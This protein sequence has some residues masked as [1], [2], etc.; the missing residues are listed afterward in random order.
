[1]SISSRAYSR[2]RQR[3]A[4]SSYP[5][6]M[7]TAERSSL[8]LKVPRVPLR[9]LRCRRTHSTRRKTVSFL[10]SRDRLQVLQRSQSK[11]LR[12]LTFKGSQVR[13]LIFFIYI[14]ALSGGPRSLVPKCTKNIHACVCCLWKWH[15]KYFI[16]EKL[17]KVDF[18]RK[19]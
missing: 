9:F 11:A 18:R 16:M 14:S 10:S 17:L 13:P 15:I 8:H 6:L 1:M 12:M 3:T 2:R 4:G 5:Q 19:D 7:M